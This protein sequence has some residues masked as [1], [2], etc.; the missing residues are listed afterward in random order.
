MC[1]VVPMQVLESHG[2][3]APTCA[4]LRAPLPLPGGEDAGDPTTT[5]KQDVPEEPVP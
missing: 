1:I 4:H 3:F 2:L 5:T